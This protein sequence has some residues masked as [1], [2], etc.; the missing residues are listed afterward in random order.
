MRHEDLREQTRKTAERVK[1]KA[2]LSKG[3]KRNRKRM[4]TV[5]AGYTVG[6]CYR[7]AEEIMGDEH[8]PKRPRIRNKRIWASVERNLAAVTQ[9]A[10]QEA[11]RRNPKH[12]RH[13][14]V[15]VYGH[16]HQLDHIRACVRRYGVDVTLVI[17]FIHV[18]EYLW[19]DA[20]RS[21]RARERGSRAMGNGT[22]FAHPQWQ[23]ERCLGGYA[24]KRH[25]TRTACR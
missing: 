7:S 25:I 8:R 9:E 3:E 4:A 2:R 11:Q 24:P 18:L 17:D 14:V 23:V 22:G 1:R 10:F 21:P 6:K 19:K 12:R 20:L 13:W 5:A 15:L 16:E